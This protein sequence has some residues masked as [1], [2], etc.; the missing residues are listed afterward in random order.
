MNLCQLTVMVLTVAAVIGAG[1]FLSGRS[2]GAEGF[3]LG[4][5][6][7]GAGLVAGI[8]AGSAIGGGAT[9]GTAQLAFQYG[10]VAWCFML[11]VGLGL[12]LLGLF[13]ARP[14]RR[15]AL[16]TVPQFLALH[17]GPRIGPAVSLI[18]CLGIFFACSSSVLPGLGM[19]SAVFGIS[20]AAASPILLLLMLAYIVFGGQRGAGISGML[21]SA[22]LWAA[23][24]AAAV[25]ACRGLS[26]GSSA[27]LPSF[28]LFSRGGGYF[29]SCIGAT[30]MGMMTGQMYIQAL[31]SA[32]DSRAAVR[33]AL[34]GAAVTAPVGLMA[35]LIGMYMRVRH[36]ETP[37]LLVL[38]QFLLGELPPWLGG[39]A[40]GGIVLAI[41]SSAAAQVLAIGTMLARDVAAGLCGLRSD[42]GLLAVNRLGIIAATAAVTLFSLANI[43]ASV[44]HWNYLSMALRAGGIFLPLTLAIA[45][46]GAWARHF[47]GA[48][49]M[50]SMLG[51]TAVSLLAALC[52]DVPPAAGGLG[53]G[54]LLLALGWRRTKA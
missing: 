40:M 20:P 17:Y 31:Y 42:R 10:L 29:T 45:G 24:L 15:S 11:G 1:V 18:S 37:P 23:L 32:R 28:S 50:V 5:R 26:S 46:G 35:S 48:W 27:E 51:S 39:M 12:V 13:F 14:L 7:S 4:G 9:I 8:I 6:R 34:I 54:A 3:S 43:D 2:G 49:V 44:L 38:P 22:V 30:A 33:G 16:E 25:L 21:K 53:T 52:W 36:P 41:I 47:S 19:V